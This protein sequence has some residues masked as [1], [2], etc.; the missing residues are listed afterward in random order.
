MRTKL[1]V[2]TGAAIA[3]ALLGGAAALAHHAFAAEFDA[4]KPVNL[5]GPVTRVEWINPHAWIHI[6]SKNTDGTTTAWMVEG[7]TP[8]TLLRR[9]ITK[10]S[11]VIGT[12]IVVRGYQS[13]D[14]LCKLPGRPQAVHGLVRHRR[15]EGR[16]GPGREVSLVAVSTQEKIAVAVSA[17]IL[18][19]AAVYWTVQILDVI[20]TLKLAYG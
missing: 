15:A 8:N 7:G 1:F 9:G 2:M 5:R 4:N 17:A 16:L 13:K 11:L 3:S 20:E 10:D 12:E 18:L 19:A 6:D 14:A